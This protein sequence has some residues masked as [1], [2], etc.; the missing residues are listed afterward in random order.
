M[1]AIF[2]RWGIRSFTQVLDFKRKIFIIWIIS[3]QESYG[4]VSL[5]F[6]RINAVFT[7]M[8]PLENTNLIKDLCFNI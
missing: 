1:P 7:E 3:T 4:P 6:V 5:L 8:W 2:L